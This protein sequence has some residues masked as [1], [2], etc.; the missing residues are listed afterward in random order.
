MDSVV[1][2]GDEPALGDTL[3]ALLHIV[4]NPATPL[5][6][7]VGHLG[8]PRVVPLI[9]GKNLRLS[10]FAVKIV[11]QICTST[12]ECVDTVL[13]LKVLAAFKFVL[14]SPTHAPLLKEVCL[15]LANIVSGPERHLQQVLSAGF[16]HE[17]SDLVLKSADYSVSILT[18]TPSCRSRR[19]RSGPSQMHA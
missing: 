13:G 5:S 7:V 12:D 9:E 10:A 15:T 19:R 11:D 1:Y 14:K 16:I 2:V 4:L 8:L 3:N 17:L 6:Q 18:V